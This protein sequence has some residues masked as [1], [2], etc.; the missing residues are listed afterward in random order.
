MQLN[1]IEFDW[2]A[3][4]KHSI[5]FVAEDVKNVYPELVSQTKDGVVE[6]MNYSK[7]VSA[8]VK[9]IQEQQNQIDELNNKLNNLKNS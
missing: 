1:P 5:G 6:G 8:L 3:N 9:S 2:T 7:L 4:K